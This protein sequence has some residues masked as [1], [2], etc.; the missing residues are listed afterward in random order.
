MVLLL[1]KHYHLLFLLV[2]V[3]HGKFWYLRKRGIVVLWK[4]RTEQSGEC[5]LAGETLNFFCFLAP[6]DSPA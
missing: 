4:R 5:V 6:S 1:K 3:V 2:L